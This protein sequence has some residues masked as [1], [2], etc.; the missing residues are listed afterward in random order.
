MKYKYFYQLGSMK[1][2]KPMTKLV[3][4]KAL[5]GLG[6]FDLAYQE[7]GDVEKEVEIFAYGHRAADD[8]YHGGYKKNIAKWMPR[9]NYTLGKV[10]KEWDR[11]Y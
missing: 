2:W 5:V 10:C 7:R 9:E 6:S 3:A 1:E 8:F 11:T 4:N